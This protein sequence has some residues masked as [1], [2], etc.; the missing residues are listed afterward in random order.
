MQAKIIK[1][2][3]C[4]II[5]RLC[6]S[7][8]FADDFKFN[9]GNQGPEVLPLTF[10]KSGL[11]LV[12]ITIQNQKFHLAIDTGADYATI[13]LK[14]A[15][16]KRITV[17]YLEDG[18]RSLDYQ[19]KAYAA[20]QFIIPSVQLGKL[21]F[22]DFKATEE[23]RE[24]LSEDDGNIGNH[25]LNHFYVLFDYQDSK[26]VLYPKPAQAGDYPRELNFG[27]LAKNSFCP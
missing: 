11:P 26:M 17:H 9:A 1:L 2:F 13:L 10:T 16:L 20:R 23:L 21:Q 5:F 25:L 7:L 27:K 6:F 8:C 12:E 24:Y 3:F 4:I 18:F 22:T 15:A 14:P 19:G